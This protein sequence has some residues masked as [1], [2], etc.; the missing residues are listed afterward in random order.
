MNNFEIKKKIV[1]AGDSRI[2]K[3]WEA[4]STITMDDFYLGAPVAVRGCIRRKRQAH[5]GDRACS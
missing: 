2:F 4:H 5:P 1:L 3:D